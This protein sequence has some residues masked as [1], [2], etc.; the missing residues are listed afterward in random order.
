MLADGTECFGMQGSDSLKWVC[1]C[2]GRENER[3]HERENGMPVVCPV[4]G[5]QQS[6]EKAAP[7]ENDFQQSQG[8]ITPDKN[9]FETPPGKETKKEASGR[10]IWLDGGFRVLSRLSAGTVAACILLAIFSVTWMGISLYQDEISL[11]RA[12]DNIQTA[13][14]RNCL[15]VPVSAA[16]KTARLAGGIWKTSMANRVQNQDILS[17]GVKRIFWNGDRHL[18]LLANRLWED[19]ENLADNGKM[20]GETAWRNIREFSAALSEKVR[21]DT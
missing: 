12:A 3:E 18:K 7:D 2:C 5:F 15:A 9:G 4:C 17:E 6:E 8:T 14:H 16:E 13:F 1:E 11:D 19:G 21:R 10:R 20:S